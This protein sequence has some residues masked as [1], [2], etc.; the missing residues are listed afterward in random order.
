M[1][2]DEELHQGLAALGLPVSPGMDTTAEGEYVVYG[3]V[4]SGSLWGDDGPCME[5]RIWSVIYCAPTGYNRMDVREQICNLIFDIFGAWPSEEP[6][7]TAAGQRF[8]YEFETI[9]DV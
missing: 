1:T 9:G 2:Q 6:E 3:Y 8:C 7:E 5:H 4:R